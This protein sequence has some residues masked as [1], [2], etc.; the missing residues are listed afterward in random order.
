MHKKAAIKASNNELKADLDRDPILR[1]KRECIE[2]E[3]IRE[4]EFADDVE[5]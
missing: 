1:L 3:I 2:K 4:E 5:Y